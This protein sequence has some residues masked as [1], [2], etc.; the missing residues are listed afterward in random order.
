MLVM[1]DTRLR[2][3]AAART[4]THNT[5]PLHNTLV[6]P[7]SHSQSAL[8]KTGITVPLSKHITSPLQLVDHHNKLLFNANTHPP[9]TDTPPPSP[10]VPLPPRQLLLKQ[11]QKKA[12]VEERRVGVE[13]ICAERMHVN[14]GENWKVST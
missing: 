14:Q 9:R 1:E 11:Q 6:P 3:H 10:A 5:R 2:N 8:M 4:H 12:G 7:V 13:V